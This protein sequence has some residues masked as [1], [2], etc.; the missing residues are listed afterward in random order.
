MHSCMYICVCVRVCEC[1]R[2][3]GRKVYFCVTEMCVVNGYGCLLSYVCN[4]LCV[5]LLCVVCSVP[6]V[7][8]SNE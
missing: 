7:C 5:L 6:D 2:V 1:A 4:C 3:A 8:G